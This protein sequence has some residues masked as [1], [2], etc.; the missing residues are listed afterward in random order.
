MRKLILVRHGE[1]LWNS[2]G[3]TQ[4]RK[5]SALT[6]RGILQAEKLAKRLVSEKIDVIYSSNLERAKST[7]AIIGKAVDKTPHYDEALIELG[8]GEWEGLTLKEIDS[9][10]PHELKEWHNNPHKATIPKAEGLE[11][12]QNRIVSFIQKISEVSN[13]KNVLIVSHGTIIKLFLLSFLNMKLCDFYRLKQGNCSLNIIEFKSR[14]PVLVK[15]N[16]MCYMEII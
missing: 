12:A 4:G 16:D 10:Y 8:F 3:R 5:N 11:I 14:G 2:E 9:R 15:Y 6:T 13:D 7:A 1:T